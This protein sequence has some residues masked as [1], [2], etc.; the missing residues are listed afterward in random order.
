MKHLI[1][2]TLFLIAFNSSGNSQAVATAPVKATFIS[3]K[4]KNNS[5]LPRKVTVISY[6]PDEPGNGTSG[7]FVGSYATRKL[8]FPIGTKIYLANSQQVDVVMSG[9]RI[10]D[11]LP[12][13]IVNKEDEG[14]V[15]DIK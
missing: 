5:I 6:R 8:R 12:F 13:L 10:T 11:D 15:F 3:F 9:A 4:I 14:K 1:I 7:Y 2:F